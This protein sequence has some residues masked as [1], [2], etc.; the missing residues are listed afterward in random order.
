MS[1]KVAVWM[2]NYNNARHL[3]RAFE[4]I[5]GQS[6]KEFDLLVF[7]N[8]STD[9]APDITAAYATLDPR[10][11]VIPMPVGLAGIDVAAFAWDYLDKADY[12]YSI[13]IGGHDVW[14][15]TEHLQLLVERMD[16]ECAIHES[17]GL[18]DKRGVAILYC[19]TWQL[20]EDGQICGRYQDIKQT[21]QIPRPFVPLYVVSGVNSP[22][23][24]G[25]WN[26]RVRKLVPIRHR[27]SGFDHLVVM[28]AALYGA[29]MWEPRVQ[30]MMRAPKA[31]DNLEKYGQRH[32]SPQVLAAGQRDFL[33][34]LEWCL[35]CTDV[36]TEIIPGPEQESFRICLTAAITGVYLML[37]GTNLWTVP[38]AYDAFNRMPQLQ[39][40]L[41]GF[42]HATRMVRDMVRSSVP[43]ALPP[44]GP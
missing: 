6:F 30:L 1:A 32:L 22:E 17:P 13:T 29:I 3:N 5:L 9:A 42:G 24:F 38:G 43:P 18:A 7:D 19:D 26:E 40:M 21:F 44:A 25:M 41:K 27:C 39:E 20:N 8:H 35:Y 15:T 28:N 33:N 12:T 31:D 23:F 34:Q 2:T 16:A 14:N 4:S 10:V 36:A 37:R 11:K